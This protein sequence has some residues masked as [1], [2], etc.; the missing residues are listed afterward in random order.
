MKLLFTE[1]RIGWNV[2]R[3]TTKKYTYFSRKT[4]QTEPFMS[5][6]YEDNIKMNVKKMECEDVTCLRNSPVAYSGK[7]V[8]QLFCFLNGKEFAE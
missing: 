4:E 8:N 1:E 2:A 3:I 7:D 5:P 6:K